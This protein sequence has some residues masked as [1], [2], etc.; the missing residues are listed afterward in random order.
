MAR[1]KNPDSINRA[2]MVTRTV[3]ERIF[4][5]K[6]LPTNSDTCIHITV[7][8]TGNAQTARRDAMR[9]GKAQGTVIDITEKEVN[10]GLYGMTL[11]DFMKAAVKLEVAESE[12]VNN[13]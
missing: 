9:Q 11:E 13:G 4:D 6:I 8:V 5:V 3:E 1:R 12:D 7:T 10:T 2:G